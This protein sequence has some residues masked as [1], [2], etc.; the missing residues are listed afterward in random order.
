MNKLRVF[1]FFNAAASSYIYCSVSFPS[2]IF[3]WFG[4]SDNGKKLLLGPGS[5]VKDTLFVFCELPLSG[6]IVSVTILLRCLSVEF[7]VSFKAWLCCVQKDVG[8]LGKTSLKGNKVL[9]KAPLRIVFIHN[10]TRMHIR[11]PST[12]G[13]FSRPFTYCVFL[14]RS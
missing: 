7:L 4:A 9:R 3:P 11:F 5:N 13:V 1:F 6:L 12:K 14:V 2:G 8:G 10:R